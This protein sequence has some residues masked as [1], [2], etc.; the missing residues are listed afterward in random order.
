MS[1]LGFEIAYGKRCQRCLKIP[2]AVETFAPESGELG[3]G[4][5]LARIKTQKTCPQRDGMRNILEKSAWA[6]TR[7]ARQKLD[8]KLKAIVLDLRAGLAGL[9]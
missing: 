7:H 9:D 8:A 2:G 6:K 1:I 5:Y 4:K 3:F